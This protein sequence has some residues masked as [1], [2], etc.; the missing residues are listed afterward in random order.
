MI[1]L[2]II[3]PFYNTIEYTKELA[4]VLLNQLTEEVE[5]IIIDDG[6][7]EKELDNLGVKVIHL[8]TNSGNSSLPRNVGLDN[9]K[10]EYI[11]FID[12]DDLVENNYVETI[13]NK[14][15]NDKFD[16]CYFGWKY[17]G[18]EYPILEE[19]EEWNTCV[20]NCIYKKELIG[21]NRFN[22]NKNL[23]EDKDF[24]EKVRKG[25]RKNIPEILYIYNW[26]KRDDSLS[27]LYARNK[28]PYERE[29]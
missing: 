1:K 27:S 23:G 17:D 28:I 4:K 29:E 10:G 6:T 25:T 21:E 9:A 8:P 11:V 7:N 13:L 12:S 19:P 14:I 16:Y 22:I 18:G 24:N 15:N 20:W 2:S 5:W 3:T 26:K